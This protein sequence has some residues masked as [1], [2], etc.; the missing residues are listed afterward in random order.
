VLFLPAVPALTGAAA[1]G[2]SAIDQNRPYIMTSPFARA[3]CTVVATV[4]AFLLSGAAA[5]GNEPMEPLYD[6][7]QVRSFEP[8][9]YPLP[10]GITPSMIPVPQ[11][12]TIG[13]HDLRNAITLI[14][15]DKGKLKTDHYFR[16]AYDQ[17]RGGDAFLPVFSGDSL[18]KDYIW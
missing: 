6:L 15:F 9:I 14:S 1:N 18:V 10:S 17:L 11:D 7:D 5:Y 4:C 16:N 12:N 3:L 2:P 8:E 13:T